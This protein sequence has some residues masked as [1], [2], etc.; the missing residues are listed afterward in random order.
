M[1]LISQV[2]YKSPEN[3]NHDEEKIRV[4]ESL[5]NGYH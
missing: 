4:K 1:I 2:I 5:K 3:D